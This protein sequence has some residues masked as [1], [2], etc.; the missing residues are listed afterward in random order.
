MARRQE[1]PGEAGIAE[2]ISLLRTVGPRPRELAQAAFVC[3]KD[4]QPRLGREP[5]KLPQ[6]QRRG[7]QARIIQNLGLVPGRPRLLR[8]VQLPLVATP[9]PQALVALT[10]GQQ[11][12]PHRLVEQLEDELRFRRVRN[13]KLLPVHPM[14]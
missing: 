5:I 4:P 7:F 10:P 3:I 13:A 14:A 8:L 2:I 11:P 12:Q 9:E 1:E 6:P